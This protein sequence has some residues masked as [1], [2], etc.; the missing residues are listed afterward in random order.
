MRR[1][2]DPGEQL[3]V[4]TRRQPR[5]LVLPAVVFV[6]LCG[7][8]GFAAGWLSRGRLEQVLPW[9]PASTRTWL[10][11]VPVALAAWVALAYCAR[12]LLAHRSLVYALTSR[13]V[14]CTERG[15][16]G[17]GREM[18]LSMIRD[19]H[20]RQ[21]VLQG[22]LRSG[23]ITLASGQAAQLTLTDVPEVR[24]FRQLILEA[25][26][27]LPA[28]GAAGAGPEWGGGAASAGPEWGGGAAPGDAAPWERPWEQR[29]D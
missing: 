22:M 6:L 19:V 5:M 27:E 17:G 20:V 16:R 24:R 11:F 1:L 23:T 14:V 26:D 28:H 29:E 15:L 9:V 21:G 12:R 13:R 4:T 8:T 2:L 10:P 18:P 25:I 7:G 3:I